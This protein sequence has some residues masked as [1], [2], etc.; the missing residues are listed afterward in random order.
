[1]V[2]TPQWRTK[3]P[4]PQLS[5][6]AS[7]PAPLFSARGSNPSHSS[8]E[9][10]VGSD[11][12]PSIAPSQFGLGFGGEFFKCTNCGACYYGAADFPGEPRAIK[13]NHAASK[14]LSVTSKPIFSGWRQAGS[15]HLGLTPPSGIVLSVVTPKPGG[16]GFNV[17]NWALLVSILRLLASLS[18]S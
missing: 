6:A 12:D 15:A 8:A 13:I 17:A 5:P 1:M 4:S 3:L 18:R 2:P 7:L 10:A 14:T 11:P 9:E 16:L